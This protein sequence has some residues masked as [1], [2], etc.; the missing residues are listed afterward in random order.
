MNIHMNLGINSYD[1]T[2][3]RGIVQKASCE[4]NLNRKVFVITDTGVPV[5]YAKTVASQCKEAHIATVESG[6]DSKSIRVFES[7]LEKMLELGYDGG[8]VRMSH[9]ENEAA[10][11]ALRERILAK[12]PTADVEYYPA[13][14]LCAF[15]AERGGMILGFEVAD[16]FGIPAE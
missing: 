10:V 1:I 9:C 6:E 3:E 8:R 16:E 5:Q 4:L 7:L 11:R 2:V 13:R 15:Y 14:A 12:F